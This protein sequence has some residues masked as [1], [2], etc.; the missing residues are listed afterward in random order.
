V[1]AKV[2]F[3]REPVQYG[4]ETY[5]P[6]NA[7]AVRVDTTP[8][9]DLYFRPGAEQPFVLYCERNLAFTAEVRRRIAANH[10]EQLYIRKAHAADY[11]RYLAEN[12]DLILRDKSLTPR[13]KSTILYDS[14]QAV[15]EEVLANPAARE[16]VQRGKAI[17]GHTVDFMTDEDFKLEHL[18]RTISCDVFLYTHSVNVVAYSV[19]LAMRAG[20]NDKATLREIANGALL[21][22]VGKSKVDPAILNKTTG[23]NSAEWEK[24]RKVPR[25]GFEMMRDAGCI[26]EIALDIILHHQEKLNGRGY[27]DQL[28]DTE[29]SRFVRIVTIADVFDAITS[30][31]FHQKPRSS[32]EALQLMQKDMKLEIDQDLFRTFIE[33]MAKP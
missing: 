29:I 18:L 26:G 8:A 9:F 33:M 12:I 10:I 7:D 11:H 2:R 22:D 32:F 1:L 27:P 4:S 20:H 5:L 24:I 6:I 19:A 15:V 25:V 30:D 31:R 28:K 14:A 3:N 17:V 23:L 16:N 21:H 13:E